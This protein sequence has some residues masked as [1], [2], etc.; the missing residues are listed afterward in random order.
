MLGAD[1]WYTTGGGSSGSR[2]GGGL[3]GLPPPPSE[4]LFLFFFA[5]QY[6]KIPTNLDPNPP[7]FRRI[8]AQNPPL[9][10]FLDPPLGGGGALWFFFLSKLFFISK[11]KQAIPPLCEQSFSYVLKMVRPFSYVFCTTG[12]TNLL[13]KKNLVPSLASNGPPLIDLAL[14]VSAVGV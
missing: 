9:K 6:M 5:C 2:G 7:P 10:E 3:G 4:V 8:L 13:L 11:T 1:Y 12:C 14:G